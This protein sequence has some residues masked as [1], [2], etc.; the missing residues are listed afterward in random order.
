MVSAVSMPQCGPATFQSVDRLCASSIAPPL[1]PI[2]LFA[3]EE[4]TIPDGE[5]E[6]LKLDYLRQPY[7]ARWFAMI[8]HGRAS[9][10]WNR[11]WATG[12]TQSGKT[13]SCFVTPIM[14]H[15]FEV[16]ETVIAGIPNMDMAGDKW[17]EDIKPA[18]EASK[19][20]DLLPRTGQG[21]KGGTP[22]RIK[23]RNGSTLLFMAAAGN[24]KQQA[25]FTAPC[26]VMTEVD[27]Y[28][29][30]KESSRESN[31]VDLM[32][33]R[34][35]SFK[36]PTIYGECTVSIEAGRIWQEVVKGTNT[37]L[38]LPCPHCGSWVTPEREH[39][40]GWE[41]ASDELEAEESGAFVCPADGCGALWSD[42]D[43]LDANRSAVLVHG[44]QEIDKCGNITGDLPRTRSASFR[45]SAV[46]NMFATSANIA[47]EEWGAK[48]AENEDEADKNLCQQVWAT[49]PED[50]IEEIVP[51]N[52]DD[53][54]HRVLKELPQGLVPEDMEFFGCTIDVHLRHLDWQA[55]AWRANAT[56]HVVDYGV[57]KISI[58]NEKSKKS[59]EIAIFGSLVEMRKRIDSGWSYQ[60]SES[61]IA[62]SLV[63]V[64]IGF[65]T[66][67]CC[68]FI[69]KTPSRYRAMMGFGEGQ[70]FKM[71]KLHYTHPSKAKGDILFVGDRYHV[72][73]DVSRRVNVFQVDAD[74][75]KT[76]A[77]KRMMASVGEPGGLTLFH[78][79]PS[80]HEDFA[81]GVTAERQITEFTPPKGFVNSWERIRR[82]NHP[83]DLLYMNCVLAYHSGCRLLR[84]S[85]ESKPVKLP[86]GTRRRG[87]RVSTSRPFLITQ[88]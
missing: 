71:R 48:R 82:N 6:G 7:A 24:S 43:R 80:Q 19:Y 77:A 32:I 44:D 40:V 17:D 59:I 22:R 11:F 37:R 87:V 41:N 39:F 4:I 74:H 60:G 58:S 14:Y 47:V 64:D 52:K 50:T 61:P 38:A 9:G 29:L 76:Y 18:I 66:D 26:L 73:R 53:I 13:L 45:W 5:F 27:G 88:R 28:D 78:A 70:H 8:D 67:T 86:S 36:W 25:A 49:P 21:S 65:E 72:K 33:G 20:R 46:N 54:P 83:F 63:G 3:L 34:T 35:R 81:K 79:M 51:L 69:R 16:R 57:E 31:P 12:P 23:F 2:S 1:R 10:M 42:G 68:R 84:S 85:G 15:L 56:P 62:P 75:W 55:I 30:A